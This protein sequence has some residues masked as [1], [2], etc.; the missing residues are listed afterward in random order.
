MAVGLAGSRLQT[1]FSKPE[2]DVPI[3]GQTEYN[4]QL[5]GCHTTDVRADI[6]IRWPPVSAVSLAI[7]CRSDE[8]PVSPMVPYAL[9]QCQCGRQNKLEALPH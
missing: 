4:N 7:N 9:L 2:Q 6:V 8:Q 1:A 5:V 3:R